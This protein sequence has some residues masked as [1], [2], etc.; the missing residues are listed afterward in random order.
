MVLGCG[1]DIAAYK[2]ISRSVI[3]PDLLYTIDKDIERTFP[4]HPEFSST[5]KYT[6]SLRKLLLNYIGYNHIDYCQGMNFIAGLLLIVSGG[7]EC[8]SY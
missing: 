2:K 3:D 7:N 5:G 8:E 1:I 4:T 6:R